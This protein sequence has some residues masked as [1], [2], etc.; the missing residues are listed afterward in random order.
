M[1]KKATLRD[2][3]NICGCSVT[4]VSRALKDSPTISAAMREKIKQTA[5]ELGYIQNSAATSMRT[6][7]TRTIAVCLQDF[8]NP[9]YATLSSYIES[10]ARS[11]GYS[12]IFSTANEDPLQGL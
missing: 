12:V 10:Y 11:L 6:G 7:Y 9:Y 4:S 1:K 3:A 2:I 8:C 5:K